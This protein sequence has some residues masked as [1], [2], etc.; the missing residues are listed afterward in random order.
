MILVGTALGHWEENSEQDQNVSCVHQVYSL[1]EIGDKQE[2][3]QQSQ[4]VIKL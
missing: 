4:V 1:V 2:N 3:K